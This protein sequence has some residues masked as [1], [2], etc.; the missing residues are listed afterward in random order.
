MYIIIVQGLY[1]KSSLSRWIKLGELGIPPAST[2]LVAHM[3]IKVDL[4]AG[5]RSITLDFDII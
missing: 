2:F 4:F 3:N 1:S 5:L